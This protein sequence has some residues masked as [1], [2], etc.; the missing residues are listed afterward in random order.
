MVKKLL[1]KTLE[2]KADSVG[3]SRA[4]VAMQMLLELNSDVRGDY[5]DEEP[6]EI[7]YN[8]PDFFNNFTV[9][10]AT[11]LVEKSL[12]LL[13]QRLWDLNIPLI[14]CRSIGF[15]AYMR[16]QVK[17][18]TVIETHPDNETPDLHL[19]KPFE[20][21]KTHL[22]SINLEEMSFKDYTHV[23]YLIILYKF[24]QKWI[25]ERKELPK[26]YKEKREFRELMK[27]GMR[28][29][30]N[31]ITSIEENFDEAIKAVNTCIGHTE[32]PDSVK[33]ILN[34]DRCINLT[35]KSSSFWIIAKAIRD[36]CE[37]EGAG[38][39]PLKGTLPD[40]TA[41]TEKY[42]TLQQIYHKQAASDAEAVWRRTLQLL[43]QL[44]KPSDSISERDVK[45]FCRHASNIYVEKGT[46]IADE[47]DSKIS[48][49]YNI[50]QSLENPESMMIYY[51]V[52][53]GV[54]K[55]QAEYNSYPGEFDDQVEPDIVKLKACIT[56]LLIEWG[57]GPLAKDD[58]VHEFCRFGG[59]ELHS[60]S[61]FL[62]GLAAQEVIKFVTNQYKPVHNTFIYDA[63]TSNSE[64]FFF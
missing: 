46:C 33:N 2:Q 34:D 17:E 57:C 4:Q 27:E 53:R 56:K 50:V 45:L 19:D 3:K 14:V 15:I 58:Y 54:E 36:F 18:H 55:F 59:A 26:T 40:M 35:A 52:L 60:V 61:A 29:H 7:L 22:D 21:L 41:D 42:I 43:R 44:G 5:I 64:T 31:D 11:S 39:L 20:T 49:T 38:L 13:S 23:P 1:M 25:T 12:I 48:D 37:N 6:E 28:K 24:L 8:S 10:V 30:E 47:Y 32:V 62:G 51:V 16:I 9:V 63:V